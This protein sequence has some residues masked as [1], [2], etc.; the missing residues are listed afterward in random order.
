MRSVHIFVC[1]VGVANFFANNYFPMSRTKISMTGLLLV[2][3]WCIHCTSINSGWSSPPPGGGAKLWFYGCVVGVVIFCARLQVTR[4]DRQKFPLD[5]AVDGHGKQC[6][7]HD[8]FRQGSRGALG[9]QFWVLN[10]PLWNAWEN[11]PTP[12][13]RKRCVLEQKGPK[14]LPNHPLWGW[15]Q[16][17]S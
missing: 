3:A 8:I 13:S 7:R 14:F 10:F 4:I 9:V 2:I 6:R 15:P 5:G 12:I 17:W 16:K 1:F 11:Y